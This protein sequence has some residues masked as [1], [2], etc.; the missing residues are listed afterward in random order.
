MNLQEALRRSADF[1]AQ[2]ER[3]RQEVQQ[4]LRQW[5]VEESLIP[6]VL[7]WLIREKFIDE[8]RYAGYF[9]R[10]KFRFNGWGRVKI[11]YALRQKGVADAIVQQS[12]DGLDSREYVQKMADLMQAKMKQAKGKDSWSRRAAVA[13]FMLSRGFESELIWSHFEKE[14][15]DG[16][17]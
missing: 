1:C 16:E 6:E 5:E 12:L 15:A 4:K 9:V 17:E 3:C 13:R 2:Q 11:G 8:S 14:G 10:D 7:D